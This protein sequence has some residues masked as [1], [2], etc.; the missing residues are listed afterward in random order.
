MRFL[1]FIA[2]FL[3]ITNTSFAQGALSGKDLSTIKVDALT[4][5]DITQIQ[6]DLK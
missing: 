6:K 4:E 2:A 3:F 5:T 1:L